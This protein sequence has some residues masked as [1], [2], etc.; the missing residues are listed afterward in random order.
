MQTSS[1]SSAQVKKEQKVP[2]VESKSTSSPSDKKVA[3]EEAKV[4]KE[5]KA[6]K[7]GPPK[8]NNSKK[9]PT[10]SN[11][12]QNKQVIT[13]AEPS[14]TFKTI[15]N[16]PIMKKNISKNSS[17]SSNDS[18][19]ENSNFKADCSKKLVNYK[20]TKVLRTDQKHANHKENNSKL[21]EEKVV[22]EDGLNEFRAKTM[23]LNKS[24][25]NS[26]QQAPVKEPV[27]NTAPDYS[28]YSE[29]EIEYM[30]SLSPSEY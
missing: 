7:E 23:Q 18:V 20:E 21:E 15:K 26:P 17:N 11:K 27:Q 6:V 3:I 1:A 13:S 10:E 9:S 5:T 4:N 2:I 29:Q 16:E 28:M 25:S 8:Y 19:C 14:E 22:V 30:T 12:D 24:N